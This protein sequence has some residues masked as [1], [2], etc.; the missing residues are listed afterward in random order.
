MHLSDS[1][2]KEGV[3]QLKDYVFEQK[4]VEFVKWFSA[5][6]YYNKLEDIQA[7]S[8]DY[9]DIR[10]DF[11]NLVGSKTFDYSDKNNR[12][13]KPGHVDSEKFITEKFFTLKKVADSKNSNDV[14]S[15]LFKSMKDDWCA[16]ESTITNHYD[17][18]PLFDKFSKEKWQE[19]IQKSSNTN[20]YRLGDY[21]PYR[22]RA[23]NIKDYL[24]DELDTLKILLGIANNYEQGLQKSSRKS[25]LISLKNHLKTAIAR[26][27]DDNDK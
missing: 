22:Y 13:L 21:L 5:A 3:C 24:I 18:E 12:K 7:L 19:F 25:V 27:S 10:N 1:E 16:I 4:E 2:F 14:L 20:I 26:L 9:P 23:N 8:D 15:E 17:M 6:L 11:D